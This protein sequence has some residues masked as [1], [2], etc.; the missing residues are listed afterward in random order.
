MSYVAFDLDNTLGYFY[1]V[2]PVAYFFSA[3]TLENSSYKRYNPSFKLSPT[4]K[5]KM[6][7]AEAAYIKKIAER[8]H[9][10]NVIL[11]PNL[12]ALIR[13]I[14]QGRLTG[15][16]RSVVIYSNNDNNFVLK[17]AKTLIEAKY[18]APGLFT[19]LVDATH[20]IRVADQ[21][22]AVAGEPAKTYRTLKVIFRKL[23][24]AFLPLAAHNIIFIDE[25]P[26]KHDVT[27]AE[28]DGLTY[29]QPTVY[30]PEIPRVHKREI[31]KLLIDVLEEQGLFQDPEYLDSPLFHCMRQTYV[32]GTGTGR[33]GPIDEFHEMAHHAAQEIAV[34]GEQ[35]VPFVDDTAA[36]RR[37]LLRALARN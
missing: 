32:E 26:K 15:R 33:F 30:A 36:L 24:G 22:R 35:A 16:V 21:E 8:Q 6:A 2:M 19:A 13:P 37:G 10:V 4:L 31:F 28:P 18:N 25:R 20:P 12:D 9:L 5:V 34:A 17:L 14:L 3:E 27:N 11:R 29:I 7:I 23:C 1:H